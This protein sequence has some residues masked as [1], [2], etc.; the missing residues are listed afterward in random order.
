MRSLSQVKGV[1]RF[2]SHDRRN[3]PTPVTREALDDHQR[4]NGLMNDKN[5]FC[6]FSPS[7]LPLLGS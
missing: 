4:K 5:S 3:M 2:P 6:R 7:V 1:L